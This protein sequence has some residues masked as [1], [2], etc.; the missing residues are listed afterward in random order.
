M[1]RDLLEDAEPHVVQMPRSRN[2]HLASKALQEKEHSEKPL[3][4][5]RHT[6]AEKQPEAAPSISIVID[7]LLRIRE[8]ALNIAENALDAPTSGDVQASA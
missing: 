7:S 8:Y 4:V 1:A 3:Q 2:T 6:A 5:T